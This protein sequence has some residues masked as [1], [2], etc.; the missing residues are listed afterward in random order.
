LRSDALLAQSS[1]DLLC[2]D[3]Q[4]IARQ[5][6]VARSEHHIAPAREQFCRKV[7]RAEPLPQDVEVFYHWQNNAIA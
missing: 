3:A 2:Y 7:P 6:A 5:L 4:V 1:S